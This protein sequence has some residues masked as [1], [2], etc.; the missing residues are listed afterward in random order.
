MLLEKL[1][2]TFADR[3]RKNPA[4]SLRAF[5][6]SL[7][8]DSSTVSAL[9][10]GKRPITLK[11]ARKIID[12]LGITNP[13]ESQALLI[14]TLS[15]HKEEVSIGYTELTLEVAEAVSSWEHFAILALFETRDFKGQVGAI[16]DRL[17]I[18]IGIVLECL[19]RL[20]KIGL[21]ARSGTTWQLTGKNMAAPSDIPSET[22]RKG[23]H[24]NILKALSSLE[25]DPIEIR[26]ISGMTMAVSRRKVVEAKRMIQDFRRRLS[27]FLEEGDRDSV[28][29]LNI[30]LFP[31]SREKSL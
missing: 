21:I 24:Q 14:A 23:H 22:L 5:A 4:Y 31:L 18:P 26:D 6:R 29:R 1:K 2:R 30:Q 12:G 19:N 25:A 16:A 10:S 28:Y 9:L 11:L 3:S 17:A 8:M 20:E 27:A 7:D 13:I 15:E